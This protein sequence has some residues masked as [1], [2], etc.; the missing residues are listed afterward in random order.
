MNILCVVL[1]TCLLS[2]L[3]MSFSY[4]CYPCFCFKRKQGN[5]LRIYVK[6]ILISLRLVFWGIFVASFVFEYLLFNLENLTL[7]VKIQIL[8]QSDVFPILV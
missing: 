1:I 3:G 7:L 6:F 2:G 8:I 4:M 5:L